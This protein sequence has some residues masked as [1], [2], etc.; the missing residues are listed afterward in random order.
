MDTRKRW[1]SIITLILS[2]VGWC[3]CSTGVDF[4]GVDFAGVDS[5]EVG[6]AAGEAEVAGQRAA[7]TG[8]WVSH[9][10]GLVRLDFAAG[11]GCSGFFAGPNMIATAAHCVDDKTISGAHDGVW[12]GMKWGE[13]RLRAVYKPSSGE[14]MCINERCRNA[15]N[16]R[17]YTT[18]L[19]FW[20]NAYNTLDTEQDVAIITRLAG[21]NFTT[22]APDPGEPAPRSLQTQDFLRILGVGV[23]EWARAR[24]YGAY[25]DGLSDTSPREG[26]VNANLW[27]ANHI[28]SVVAY[29]HAAVCAGDS[30]GPLVFDRDAYNGYNYDYA[31]GVASK[32]S[33]RTSSCPETGD[34]MYW[35]RLSSKIWMFDRILDWAGDPDCRRFSD[36]DL[37]GNGRYYRCW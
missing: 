14:V 8:G 16:S 22:R 2:T 24:G 31:G 1:S 30:G 3:G 15:N 17:R 28:R 4:A 23:S 37:P 36:N 32:T 6:S 7:I 33:P 13:I 25:S 5:A 34:S 27:G 35:A 10:R 26:S 9:T 11:G 29:G 12:N 21:G 20:P 19:A 18:V